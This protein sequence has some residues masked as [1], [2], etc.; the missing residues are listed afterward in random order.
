ML[1]TTLV[2]RGIMRKRCIGLRGIACIELTEKGGLPMD[3]KKYIETVLTEVKFRYDHDE[4][5]KELENHIF[6]R[7]AYL[8][9]KGMEAKEAEAE[10]VRRMGDPEEMGKE[11]NRAHNPWIGWL[12]QFTSLIIMLI[13]APTVIA[14]GWWSVLE[15]RDILSE[16]SRHQQVEWIYD[17]EEYYHSRVNETLELDG[18]SVKFTDAYCGKL[19]ED[20]KTGGYYLVLFYKHRGNTGERFYRYVEADTFLNSNGA[21]Y[22]PYMERFGGPYFS[23]DDERVL[24]WIEALSEDIMY[25]DYDVFG[26]KATGKIDLSGLFDEME[27]DAQ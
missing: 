20:K 5:T 10:A 12:W 18:Y 8:R 21:G 11:M 15:V 19:S 4:I 9:A 26:Q 3:K 24:M 22:A 6:E 7:S 2:A 13:F 27:R 25:I 16:P 14:G 17:G 23:A 1:L